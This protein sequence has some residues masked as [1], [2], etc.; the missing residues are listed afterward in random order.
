VVAQL[1]QSTVRIL[2]SPDVL[3]RLQAGGAEPAPSTPDDFARVIARDIDTWSRV[4]KTG[5][6]KVN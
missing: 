2:K 6:I 3:E 1:N 5:N 4:V